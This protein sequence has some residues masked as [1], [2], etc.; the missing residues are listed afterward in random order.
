MPCVEHHRNTSGCKDCKAYWLRYYHRRK[1]AMTYG[2]WQPRQPIETVRE[3]L[4]ACLAAE[5]TLRDVARE[6]GIPERTVWQI[7]GNGKPT[8]KWVN[9][10]TAA[11]ILAVQPRRS[12][13]RGL[14]DAEVTRRKIRAMAWL[15]YGVEAQAR[16]I[17]VGLT[18]M[19]WLANDKPDGTPRRPYVTPATAAKVAVLFRR[20][21]TTR[22]PDASSNARSAAL[23]KAWHGPLDWP[24]IDDPRCQPETVTDAT[25]PHGADFLPSNVDDA[26]AGIIPYKVLTTA[27]RVRVVTLLA[28]RGWSDVRIGEWLRWPQSD[29][30]T[31]YRHS[32]VLR[33]R[34]Y[35]AIPTGSTT[36]RDV[37]AEETRQLNRVTAAA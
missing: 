21:S 8:Q 10:P 27:E 4:A 16:E 2:T 17:G 12:V 11:G 25:R 9:G 23:K 24:N 5:M 15:G 14:V 13:P 37:V 28:R 20:W 22:C 1:R 3:H 36:A 33:F 35:H 26:L 34:R 19:W 30:D 6:S 32:P 18:S 7:H 31:Q 29:A